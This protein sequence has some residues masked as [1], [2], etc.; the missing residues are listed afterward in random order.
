MVKTDLNLKANNAIV[1]ALKDEIKKLQ[2]S[3]QGKT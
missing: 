1:E 3:R 2:S